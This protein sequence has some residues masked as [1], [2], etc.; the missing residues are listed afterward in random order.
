MANYDWNK[1]IVIADAFKQL[2][3]SRFMTDVQLKFD[4]GQIIYAHKIVLCLRSQILHDNFDTKVRLECRPI[5]ITQQFLKFLYT[6]ACDL[7]PDNVFE[8]VAMSNEL[9]VPSLGTFCQNYL[10]S[11]LH[12]LQLLQ[13][14]LKNNLEQMKMNSLKSIAENFAMTLTHPELINIGSKT[15][16][17]ILKLETVSNPQEFEMFK[18]V[19]NWADIKCEQQFRGKTIDASMK[20]KML[21]N[22]LFL[23][24]FAAMTSAEFAMCIQQEPGLLTETECVSI[25]LSIAT[26]NENQFGFSCQKRSFIKN[27]STVNDSENDSNDEEDDDDDTVSDSESDNK[28]IGSIEENKETQSITNATTD[29]KDSFIESEYDS[30]NY[31]NSN[32]EKNY[33][34]EKNRVDIDTVTAEFDSGL[35]KTSSPLFTTVLQNSSQTIQDESAKNTSSEKLSSTDAAPSNKP[36]RS[37]RRQRGGPSKKGINDDSSNQSLSMSK[38]LFNMSSSIFLFLKNIPAFNTTEK[39]FRFEFIFKQPIQLTGFEFI[40]RPR[41]IELMLNHRGRGKQ[42]KVTS[43]LTKIVTFEPIPIVPQR[44]CIII[45]KFLDNLETE[46][47]DSVFDKQ[48]PAYLRTADQQKIQMLIFVPPVHIS[49]IYFNY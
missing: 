2:Y 14:S 22:N 10:S 35:E 17:A 18:C 28:E 47:I 43:A 19:L 31:D 39:I 46:V 6:D 29:L 7:C 48:C 49:R 40:G 34:S 3:N 45:Y 25:F 32:N 23:I 21:G 24:R 15:L 9:S 12:P 11:N 33:T 30:S 44:R 8:L 37:R 42:L 20:R 26:G 1:T 5:E 27:T 38:N 36:P 41:P 13:M 4:H 16:N